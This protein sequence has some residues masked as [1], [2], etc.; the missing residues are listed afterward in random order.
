MRPYSIFLLFFIVSFFGGA[1]SNVLGL[2]PSPA[3]G[4]YAA[5]VYFSSDFHPK[6]ARWF[7]TPWPESEWRYQLSPQAPLWLTRVDPTST[8][9]TINVDSTKTYQTV[10][11]MGTS[12]EETSIYALTKNHSDA[13]IKEILK[14]LI[15]PKTGIGMNLFRITIGT[16]DFSDG[17]SVSTDPQGF[18]TYQDQP[19][20]TFSIENDR[21]LNIIHVLKLAMEVAAESEQPIHFFASAWS[22]PGWMKDSGKLIGGKLRT[23]KI[24]DYA[25]Y[26]RK[27]VHAYQAEGIPIYAITTNNEHYFAPDRYPGCF[28]DAGQEK[29]LVE[30]IGREFK[31]AGLSTRIWILDHNFDIW[32]QAAKT[33]AG[34][35]ADSPE[36]YDFA[37]GVAYHHYGGKPVQMAKLAE[38]FPDKSIQF[39]EGA[40]WGMAGM[41]EIA[42]IFRN[43]S[44]SYVS[45]VTM[46]TQ[47]PQEHIQGPYNKPPALSPV[48]L[49]KKD[50]PGPDWYKIPE[51][52]LYG[53]FMKFI[54]PGAV[55]IE[56]DPGSP[57]TTT[58]VAFRN[59][60][61]SLVIVAINQCEWVQDFRFIIDGNQLAASLPP[62][63]MATYVLKS[64]L[65]LSTV[66]PTGLPDVGPRIS[67]PTGSGTALKEWW[68]NLSGT[69]RGFDK[70]LNDPRFPANPSGTKVL[71]SLQTRDEWKGGSGTRLRGFV[72]PNITGP[73]VFYVAGD[74]SAELFLS[75]DESPENKKLVAICPQWAGGFDAHPQQRSAPI[76]LV[77]GKKY[78]FET[79]QIGG[80]G[81]GHTDVGWDLPGIGSQKII[82]GK[83]LSPP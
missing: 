22:P 80:G 3:T 2:V 78:Y 38:L 49:T 65:K 10:L 57:E 26:L 81:N 43:G 53:Q 60:D 47:T 62:S 8:L 63:T 54:R 52:N 67:P 34:L 14:T 33:L 79:L 82:W 77:A 24:P 37:D 1:K 13:Q 55:R 73:Y 40:V 27:F 83:F 75:T 66:A 68:L 4:D 21:K 74:S 9:T 46:A 69:G 64:G 17:R 15:D 11:G 19:T 30:A 23:D 6:D 25:V 36:S 70:L 18:Y 16:S 51:Y 39:T 50:G 45:W 41:D 58:N 44:S 59:P 56:S 76:Q 5:Q 7:K 42:Q 28:F 12:L 29:L 71:T 32:K 72:H 35:K 20:D 31:Q 48:L 61:G